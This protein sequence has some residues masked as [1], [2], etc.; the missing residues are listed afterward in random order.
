MAKRSAAEVAEDYQQKE[1]CYSLCPLKLGKVIK[2]SLSAVSNF[3][4]AAKRYN[5]HF[6]SV[7]PGCK[8]IIIVNL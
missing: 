8:M 5:V 3:F 1:P 6:V 2:S 7:N 4:E